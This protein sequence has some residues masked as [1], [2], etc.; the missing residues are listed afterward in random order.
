MSKISQS[1]WNKYIK[2]MASI[3]QAAA[4]EMIKFMGTNPTRKELVDFAFLTVN[5]YGNASAALAGTMYELVAELE[6][7]N[8]A[9]AELAATPDY[10]EVAKTVNGVL[11]TSQNPE[12]MGGAV[13]R[14]V[15]RTGAD[16]T[17]INAQRDKAQ[18]AWIP[19]G[20]TCAFCITLASRGWQDI[21]KKALRNGH[22]EHIHSN[23]DCQYC[24]RFNKNTEVEGYDPDEYYTQYKNAEGD[25][26][27]DKINS[28]RRMY[29]AENRKE[30][31]AQKADNYE[32]R[33][34]LESSKAEE[35]KVN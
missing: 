25:K 11:K 4:N 19:A 20:D 10:G 21:S 33:K 6:G 30:I 31:L 29:Y 3:N 16:T 35:I 17:L 32:K 34:E 15:K 14:L 22:A 8:V 13:G 1:D 2:K 18:F 9:A 12:E 24:I 7:V 27:K 28:M 26:P 23:C 5:Q